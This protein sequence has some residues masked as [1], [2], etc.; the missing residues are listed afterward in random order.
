MENS[1]LIVK[2]WGCRGS[3]P[4]SP[5]IS[6]IRHKEAELIKRI[7]KDGGTS[8]FEREGKIDNVKIERYLAGLPLSVSGTYGGATTCLELQANDSPLIILDMGTG[9]RRLGED[10]VKRYVTNGNF[11]PLNGID[12]NNNKLCILLS[13]FHYDHT[14]GITSFIPL[15]MPTTK[16]EFFG[17]V[18]VRGDN[19]NLKDI[20]EG[21]QN[22]EAFPVSLYEQPSIRDYTELKRFDTN[23]RQ[24][25]N[26]SLRHGE[27]SHPGGC[28]AYG[29]EL[30]NKT[31]IFATDTE[32]RDFPEP[33]ILRLAGGGYQSGK[34]VTLYMDSQ[35]TPEEFRGEPYTGKGHRFRWGHSHYEAAVKTALGASVKTL[36]LGHHAPERDD[37][38][39]EEMHMRALS[40]RD[41]QLKL[42]KNRDK[43][44]EIVMAYSGLELR[45]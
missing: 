32:H 21:R 38:G 40:F 17:Q 36:I 34:D 9:A 23:E 4:T 18:D 37:F 31:F 25:G 30:E 16:V 24:I 1:S 26:V 2:I 45:L 8:R 3:E 44:L 14:L 10:L 6:E 12:D 28:L 27:L 42:K 41:S 35:F 15:F 39:I 29:A 5:T 33:T 11:N 7:I 19:K 20:L 43:N 13:H 22:Y